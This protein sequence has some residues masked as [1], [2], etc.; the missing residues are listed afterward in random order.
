[1]SFIIIDSFIV[2]PTHLFLRL[3]LQDV[4]AV[5]SPFV[6]LFF[7]AA[8]SQKAHIGPCILFSCRRGNEFLIS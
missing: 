7:I 6:Y 4:D 2:F 3:S 5:I 8:G 1:M